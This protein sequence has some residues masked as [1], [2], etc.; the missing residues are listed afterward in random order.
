MKALLKYPATQAL[1]AFLFAQYIRLVYYT[2]RIERRVDPQA[3]PYVRGERNAIFAFWHGRMMLMPNFEPPGRRMHVLSSHHRDG[4]LIGQVIAHFGERTIRG[5]SSRGG[6]AAVREMRQALARGENIS[7]TPDGP[8]GPF[9]QAAAGIVRLA[10]MT[11]YPVVPVTY[12]A[13]R[14]RRLHSWDRFM[15]ALPFARVVFCAGEPVL[16]DDDVERMRLRLET[17]LSALTDDA[18]RAAC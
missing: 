9:Q 11:G 15:L 1:A 17:Q 2:A 5:S 10:N 4:R 3:Q 12:G 7:I 13:S 16:R 14:H 6:L 18:D 8:R